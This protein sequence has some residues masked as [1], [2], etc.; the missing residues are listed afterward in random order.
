[1]KNYFQLNID[2]CFQ[3]K[4]I[5]AEEQPSVFVDSGVKS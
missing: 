4:Q 5:K 1:M 2:G 3:H